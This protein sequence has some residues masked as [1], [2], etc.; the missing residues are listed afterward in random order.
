MELTK[1]EPKPLP[2]FAF[3]QYLR[4]AGFATEELSWENAIRLQKGETPVLHTEQNG[5]I[6][7][8]YNQMPVGFVKQIKNRINNY[9]PKEW[10]ISADW[11]KNMFKN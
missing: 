8:T 4:V 9:F 1:K 10:K 2:A 5:W 3:S 11:S 6:L 7:L